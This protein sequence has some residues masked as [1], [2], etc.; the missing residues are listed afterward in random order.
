MPFYNLHRGNFDWCVNIY[1][2]F[3]DLMCYRHLNLSFQQ[4]NVLKLQ[5]VLFAHF[6]WSN[7]KNITTFFTYY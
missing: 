1:N 5:V 4:R 3:M 7:E 6:I 2:K